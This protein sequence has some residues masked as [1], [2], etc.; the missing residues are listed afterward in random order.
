MPLRLFQRSPRPTR[1][2]DESGSSG[3]PGGRR[4]R[5]AWRA[6]SLTRWFAAVA[7]TAIATLA[8]GLGT[9]LAWFFSDRLMRQQAELTTEFVQSL[10]RVERPM[11]DFFIDATAGMTPDVALSFTHIALIPDVLRA[12]VYNRERRVIWSSEARL[13]GRDFGPNEELEEALSG[14]V[15][16][17]RGEGFVVHGRYEKEWAARGD[18]IFLEIYS[19]VRDTHG[20]AVI[21][22]IEFYKVPRGLTAALQELHLYI[23]FGSVAG[24]G[25]LYL[26]LIGL[27]RRADH[28]MR[29][30]QDELRGSETLAAIGEMSAAV[31]HGI[32]NPLASI[33]SSAELVRVAPPDL[34]AGAADDVISECDR[35]EAWV[36]ELLSYARPLAAE[37]VPVAWPPLVQACL[38]DSAR[39]LRRRG[40]RVETDWPADL[41]AVRGQPLLLGQVVRSLLSNALEASGSGQ[42]LHLQA[43]LDPGT[44]EVELTLRDQGRG[45]DAEQLKR[46]G[47][48]FFTTKARGLGVGLSLAHRVIERLGGSLHIDSVAGHGTTVSLRLPAS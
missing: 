18:Q 33:R 44:Q 23:V 26:A 37:L 22:A 41:P 30:Q 40:I 11:V 19:P 20:G 35:L 14:E 42:S 28:T 24:A 13:I 25:F 27:I 48:P 38:A 17:H 16:V 12:N 3:R 7:F 43:R 1:P 45:M 21:G 15:V 32:R 34:A 47:Q 36:N 29:R 31:A 6:F 2:G 10:M 8:L 9:M 4:R 5:A 46:A 39:E